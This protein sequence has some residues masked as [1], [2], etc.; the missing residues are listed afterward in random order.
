[1]LKKAE[2]RGELVNAAGEK[3]IILAASSGNTGCSLALV[4]TLM[5]YEVVIITNAKCSAEKCAHIRYKHR[6]PRPVASAVAP[7]CSPT[8][9]L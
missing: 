3:K 1:M 8:L 7:N 6:H 2:A 5:G 4:G 9:W